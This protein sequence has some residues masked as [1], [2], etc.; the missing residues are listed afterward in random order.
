MYIIVVAVTFAAVTESEAI[1]KKKETFLNNGTLWYCAATDDLYQQ[2]QLKITTAH[3]TY[4]IE[5][6]NEKRHTRT[7]NEHSMKRE[8]MTLRETQQPAYNT[9]VSYETDIYRYIK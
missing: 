3:K 4:A 7:Q 5:K 9:T 1:T 8:K 2:T 6:H